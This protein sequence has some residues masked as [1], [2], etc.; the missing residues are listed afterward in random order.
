MDWIGGALT[1][2]LE[3]WSEENGNGRLTERI[4][5]AFHCYLLAQRYSPVRGLLTPQRPGRPP[6]PRCRRPAA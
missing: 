6:A 5:P 1:G 2:I 4:F 3:I